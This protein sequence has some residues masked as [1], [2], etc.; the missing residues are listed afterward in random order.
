MLYNQPL[1]TRF[2][3][4]LTAALDSGRWTHLDIA[5]AWVRASG[6]AHLAPSLG[7]FLDRGGVLSTTVG[8]DLDNTTTDGLRSLLAI[9]SGKNANAFVHH[10]ESGTIF[11]PKLYLLR[12][13]TEARLIIGSNNVTEAGMFRNTEAT[14]QLDLQLGDPV[15]TST[16]EALDAWRDV[17]TGLALPLDEPLIQALE[18]NGYIKSEA[19]I[20]REQAARSSAGRRAAGKL[21]KLFKSIHVSAPSAPRAPTSS[22]S[23]RTGV[24]TTTG[25]KAVTTVKVPAAATSSTASGQV[26][27]MRVRKAHVTDRP[28]QTQIP[29]V[30]M[31]STFF[32]GARSVTSAHTGEVH[33]VSTAT[34]R[35]SVNTLKLEI[36]EMR[37]MSDPVV[38][39]EHTGSDIQYEVYD[40][41]TPQGSTVMRALQNGLKSG[42]A[43]PTRLTRPRNPTSA[44]WWRFV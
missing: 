43:N 30:V 18:T 4:E 19:Q 38:R 12:N 6:L 29:A 13:A 39:F 26:L 28:T 16:L 32:N 11:H 7:A 25:K 8:V 1:A 2:G 15:L 22:N 21:S 5:V 40:A 3:F 42:A 36:P 37:T 14:L 9:G 24:S 33:A 44:T 41:T 35:G 10:N 17:T 23:N 31:Q 34:A 20:R 27:L